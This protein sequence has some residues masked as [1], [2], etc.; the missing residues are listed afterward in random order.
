MARVATLL[1]VTMKLRSSIAEAMI[2]L[3]NY[4][5]SVTLSFGLCE[6]SENHSI[7]S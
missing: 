3:S 1:T 5:T 2:A 6:Y 7:D 4:K